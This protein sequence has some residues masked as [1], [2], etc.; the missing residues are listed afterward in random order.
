MKVANLVG[1]RFKEKPSDCVID[2]HALMVRGGYMK[3]VGNGIYSEFPTLRRVTSKIENIIRQEMDAIDGQE[4]L[5]P[6]VLPADLWDESGRY[7]SVGS[8]LLRFT[9]RND[10]RMVLGMTHEEAAVQLV[11]EYAQSYT[12]YPFMIYQFQRKFRDE[13][14]PRA[15]MIRVREFTMKDAYSFHT[16][17]EDLEKYYDVCYQAY[18]R[19]FQKAGI[20]E[21]VTVASDSGM[22][23]GN[24]SHEYMLLTPVGEDSIVLCEECDYRANMEAAANYVSGDKIG[25]QAELAMIETPDCKTIEDVC[26][27][28]HSD[29]ESSCKAVVYQKASNGQFVVGFVRGDYEVNETKLRNLVGEEIYPAEITEDS[30]L[31]AGYIGPYAIS[32]EVEYYLDLTLQGIESMVAGANKEGYHY[33]GLNLNRDLKDAKYVDIAKVKDG[34]VCPCCGKPA[35]TIKRGIEVGNIFQ[36]G[37]KYTKAMNM[38][39]TDENGELKNPIMGCYGIGVGRMAASI[40]EAHH[41]EYGPIWPISIAPWEVEVCCLRADDE[42]CKKVADDIYTG[43]QDDGIETIY[44]DRDVRPG[45]MFSDADLIGAPIRVVVSPRNLKESKVEI[46]TR[47]KAVKEMVDLDK[48]K[49]YVIALRQKLFDDIASHVEAYQK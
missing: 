35:I 29:V 4:V 39:Y 11:R 40:C 14:R 47:D 23:G 27:F 2:S 43:L 30:C 19:I 15:G 49:E 42:E 34:S 10:A 45:A 5:F 26:A 8:E 31:V 48:A 28:L 17:Q 6:V 33:T 32:E 44:D 18:N 13:A 7:E 25:E 24:I 41:D 37:T 46:T 12:K 38:T 21:V 9:D 1:S 36:L 22:M 20:P 3:Y 16:S